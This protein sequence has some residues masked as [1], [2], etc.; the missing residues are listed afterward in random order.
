MMQSKE[1]GK[2]KMKMRDVRSHTVLKVTNTHSKTDFYFGKERFV[3][4]F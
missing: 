3:R 2:A 1:A 4:G